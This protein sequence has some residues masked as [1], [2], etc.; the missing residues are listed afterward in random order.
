[1]LKSPKFART[2]ETTD[3]FCTRASEVGRRSRYLLLVA[4]ALLGACGVP[5]VRVET[6]PM[7]VSREREL[8]PHRLH[9][10]GIESCD[11]LMIYYVRCKPQIDRWPRDQHADKA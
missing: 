9:T 5:P 11:A 8:A 6:S 10:T 7:V 3:I 2:D 4:L 1:M